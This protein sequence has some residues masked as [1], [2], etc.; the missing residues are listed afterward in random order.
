MAGRT[1]W[2]A[3]GADENRTLVIEVDKGDITPPL[4]SA[5]ARARWVAE[6]RGR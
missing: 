3:L 2:A 4:K 6:Q 1:G 5:K